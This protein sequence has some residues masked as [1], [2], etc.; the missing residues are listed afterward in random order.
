MI[1]V[2]NV[3]ILDNTEAFQLFPIEII[4]VEDG[5]EIVRLTSANEVI[6]LFKAAQLR[7]EA[8]AP[9]SADA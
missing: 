4:Y 7:N 5:Q 2:K 1:V 6:E 3:R 9:H 8:I